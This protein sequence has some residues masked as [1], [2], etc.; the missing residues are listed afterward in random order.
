MKTK[1]INAHWYEKPVQLWIDGRMFHTARG[2]YGHSGEH[3]EAQRA[4]VEHADF[5]EWL[6]EVKELFVDRMKA[7]WHQC[8]LA[9]GVYCKAGTNRSVTRARLIAEILKRD[10][11]FIVGNPKFLQFKYWT[12]KRKVCDCSCEGCWAQN[13][14]KKE[15]F[16]RA[17]EIWCRV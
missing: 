17:Y 7:H 12:D 10:G 9:V 15:I 11:T 3:V 13:P 5:G 6:R 2:P 4:T 1:F 14:Q 8:H 16:D